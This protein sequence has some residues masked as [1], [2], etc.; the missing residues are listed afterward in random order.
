MSYSLLKRFS[1][2]E[3]QSKYLS[4]CRYWSRHQTVQRGTD[5]EKSWLNRHIK[6]HNILRDL[7]QISKN[8]CCLLGKY[9]V[10]W[11]RAVLL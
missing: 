6:R 4:I 7:T 5:I 3:Y 10:Y 11:P 9:E 2:F 1:V 8:I